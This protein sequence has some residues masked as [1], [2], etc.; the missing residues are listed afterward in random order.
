M[1]VTKNP[2]I[3]EKEMLVKITGY[4]MHAVD[5]VFKG[6]REDTEAGIVIRKAWAELSTIRDAT[7]QVAVEL[8]KKKYHRD[9]N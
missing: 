9:Q 7:Q 5:A 2:F 8:L 1:E 6:R 4:S 3:A